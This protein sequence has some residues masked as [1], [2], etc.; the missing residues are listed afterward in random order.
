M[1]TVGL[2]VLALFL[3]GVVVMGTRYWILTLRQISR[4][5]TDP[6]ERRKWWLRAFF[7]RFIGVLWYESHRRE[8]AARNP[9]KQ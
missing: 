6:K 3:F 7:L 4:E 2:V 1:K 5:E 8:Q 9:G